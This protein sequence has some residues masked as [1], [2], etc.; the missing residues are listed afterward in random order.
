MIF[1][2]FYRNKKYRLTENHIHQTKIIQPIYLE[3]H[4]FLFNFQN[5]DL[6]V[7]INFST[8]IVYKKNISVNKKTKH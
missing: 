2:L 5:L 7:Y 1:N 6:F 8:Y 4:K 3:L